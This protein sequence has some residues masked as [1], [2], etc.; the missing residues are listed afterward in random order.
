MKMSTPHRS[1]DT[2]LHHYSGRSYLLALVLFLWA[3][4]AD[5]AVTVLHYWRMG[6]DDSGA[7]AG[8][9]SSNTVD[10]VGGLTLTNHYGPLYGPLYSSSVSLEAGVHT[11]SKLC[12]QF[13]TG[14]YGWGSLI[15]NVVNNFGIE[16]WVCTSNT[17][18]T[19]CLAYNGNTSTS[20]WGLYQ[21]GANYYGL[22]GGVV[23]F[24]AAPAVAGVWQHL[25]LVRDNGTTTLYLNGA[26]VSSST[27]A[28]NIPT[29]GFGVGAPALY[30]LQFFSGYLDEVRVFTFAAGQFSTNDLLINSPYLGTINLLVGP[31][32]G[33]NSVVLAAAPQAAWQATNNVAWL[34]VGATFQSGIGS[35]NVVFSYDANSGV[36]RTGTLT[37][38]GF[39]LTVTQAGSTYVPAP[40]PVTT[41]VG[42]GLLF[43]FGVAV[44]GAGNVYIADSGNNAIEQWAAPNGPVTTRVGSGL[45]FPYGVAVDGA[46][47]VY[48]ADS[49]NNA[50]KQWAAPNGPVTTLVGS[51]LNNPCGVAVDG[52]GNVYIVDTFNYA[53]K[54]W[55]A[56]NRPVTT[57]VGSGLYTPY[58]VAVDGAGNVYIADSG[59]NAIKKWAAPNGPV[60]TLV[61]SGLYS[62]CG[63]AVDG[64]GNVYIAD[65]GNNA[66]KEWVAVSNTVTTLV[67]TGLSYPYG[68]AVDGAGNVYITDG[69]NNAIKELPRAFVDPTPRV[70][71]ATAGTDALPVVLPATANLGGPFAPS[72]DQSWLTITSASNGIVLFSFAANPGSPRTAYI[73]VLGQAIPVQQKAGPALAIIALLEGPAAGTDSVVFAVTSP[74]TTWTAT[75]NVAWLH[76][77]ARFQ[78]GVGSTNVVFS[79]DANSGVTRT[80]TLTIAGLTLTVTQA[81]STYVPAPAVTTLVGSGLNYP[82]GVAVDGAGNVY[83][84]D[85]LNSAIK[86]WAAP[87]GP[88]T[89]LVGSGLNNPYGVAVDGAGNVYIADTYD[90]AIKQ[91]AAPNGPVTTLVG[92]GLYRPYGV[93]VDAAGNV[94]IADTHHNAI[95]EWVAPNGPVTTLVGSGLSYPSGVAVDGAGNVYI[96]DYGN[97]AIKEWVTPNG[98]VTTLVGSG[99]DEPWGVAVDGAGNVYIAD[100]G[101]WTVKKWVAVSNIVTTLVG[102]GLYEPC[103]VAVDGAGNVYIA[104][105]YNKAIKE[106]PR[107]F[108][109]PTPRVE[110]SA[111]GTDALPVV[112]PATANL[113]G[114]F[115]PSSDQSWLTITSASNGIVLFSF[116][117]NPGFP[118]T[119]YI[120]VLG[121]SIPI[122][123]T[124]GPVLAITALL[125]G[126]A[127]G[128][129]SVVF[130]ASSPSTPWTATAN[131]A[132]LHLGAG[133]QSGVGS[134]NVV[135]SY[136]PNS[137]VT[138]TGTL[139]IAGLTLTVT[140]AG[141]TY[142]PAPAPVTTL[143][144]SGLDEP[145]GVAVDG[146][147]N[148]YIADTDNRA[149]KEWVAVSNTVTTLVG[150]G[151]SYPFG[152]AVDG[153]GNVY[154]AD[155]LS[156]AIK[157]WA[158][159]NGPLTTLVGSGLFYPRGVAVDGAGNVYIADTGN[160]AVK[161]WVAVSNT[162]T[163][164]IGSGLNTPCGVALDGAG[165][166]YIADTYNWAVKQWAAPNG[167]VTT[168]VGS[169]LISPC[170]VAADGAGNVYIADTENCAIKEWVAV[171]NTVTTLV[172]SGLSNPSG[173][174]VDGAGNV[175]IADTGNEAIEEL[176]RAFVDPTPRMEPS[177]A[178]TDALPVVLP[179]TANL[180]GPFT[181]TSSDPS[182]LTV[183]IPVNG[184]V[185]FSFTA[186][187]GPSR[188][189]YINLFD[190]S[191]PVTQAASPSA[192]PTLTGVQA[193]TPGSGIIQFTFTGNP[194]V[195]FTV[196]SSTNLSLPLSQWTVA[197]APVSISPGVFQFTSQPT[198]APQGFFLVT[199]P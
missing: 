46:G 11:G 187:T 109:D 191:I 16:L 56:P 183:I 97:S 175:Y 93:A 94:Y 155:T 181:P 32:A 106:L 96:A 67:G 133:F 126:P 139:T 2:H 28:P 149:I 167:P 138:R 10:M 115:A 100:S 172:G 38:A 63:V 162:V 173:V 194:S 131:V 158:A 142:V 86:Q 105:T 75:A 129:D 3:L 8:G 122:R 198:N 53:I 39:T 59:N 90:S 147:G 141:S 29:G 72:S 85:T 102:S 128:T 33:T 60:T 1:I 119:A 118:R 124:V 137:G 161:K 104:D 22:F 178:G 117:A 37:I 144:G 69:G 110:P 132:W 61:R 19:N 111:A 153:A 190:Q 140:Q 160:S 116:T 42:S 55:A 26:V 5:A 108:V 15:S 18:G 52:A 134:T 154:I 57:L 89:T 44:D 180:G 47:N 92:S 150:S 49:G 35:T 170:G 125:E 30:A 80:G 58:G 17:T 130:A 14:S 152:V 157:Q 51:G 121:Q 40:A 68:V 66:I 81:G 83:I 145:F 192:P 45:N 197:G 127:A 163:T 171:S 182:W 112:L 71:A 174:A 77:G 146:A 95:K 27:S 107:A 12:L 189:A 143:V 21:E 103:G 123:Q 79:Y 84:A 113:S 73:T 195:S 101:S 78:S 20:G 99:L 9:I 7:T 91:W 25:A 176:P 4:S 24:G 179:A 43:P 159:P 151:L 62:P 188:T 156:N 54:K 31:D 166:V 48:I 36:T 148:V 87:N 185:S 6:E 41:L 34:Q 193:P 196:L 50:I 177:A 88:V 136:D 114:P 120:T 169:G 64:A 98:P 164:L 65:T 23:M 168:L 199:A 74:S 184:V 135:F 82:C 165:N 13:P 70:E 76:L 186:N